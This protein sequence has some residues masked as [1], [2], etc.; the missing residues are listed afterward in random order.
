M[1]LSSKELKR[2]A[3]QNLTFHYLTP[4]LAFFITSIVSSLL[5]FPFSVIL[6]DRPTGNLLILFYLAEFLILLV[7]SVFTAGQYNIHLHMARREE[8]SISLL[9][10]PLKTHPDRYILGSLILFLA[11]LFCAMPAFVG[12]ALTR[13]FSSKILP[14]TILLV[15]ISLVF[16]IITAIQFQFLYFVL[17]DNTNA[18]LKE[19]IP[20]ALQMMN[21]NQKRG[22]F[23]LFSFIGLYILSLLSFGIGIIWVAP[24][25]MQ[26]L[27][28]F[29]LEVKG[30]L[31]EI[32]QKDIP[33]DPFVQRE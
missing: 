18:P 13:F 11:L 10:D 15:F 33:K 20:F 5:E 8:Y 27:T 25:Q 9:F 2:I 4:I 32:L 26:S 14:L 29:Y 23:L 3:R 17:L 30:E 22:F 16:C 1:Q 6:G 31:P 24:Y 12:I 28:V 19:I 21:K 7:G